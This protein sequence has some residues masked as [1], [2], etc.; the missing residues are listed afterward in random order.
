MSSALRLP[1]L[2]V[3]ARINL[4][5][6]VPILFENDWRAWLRQGCAARGTTGDHTSIDFFVFPK[7]LYQDVPP[8]AIGR[9]W[10]DQWMIKAAAQRGPV[11]DISALT[12]IVHQN[13]AYA[14]VAGGRATVYQGP[15]AESNFAIYG[16]QAHRYTL[17]NCTHRLGPDGRIRK[18]HFRAERFRARQL[19]WDLLVRR[20]GPIR[21]V[22]RTSWDRWR[23]RT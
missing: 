23:G 14:H 17:L 21:Q 7:D 5:L 6:D 2:M 20:T 8:L 11:I 22:F 18:L 19:F 10:F 4:D 3:S 9:A 13:H 1:F 12:P 16:G 15:E